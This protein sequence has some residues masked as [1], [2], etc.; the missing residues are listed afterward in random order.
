MTN[1]ASLLG[2]YA[3][4]KIANGI[5]LNAEPWFRNMNM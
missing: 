3:G 2:G 5:V 4:S 1:P